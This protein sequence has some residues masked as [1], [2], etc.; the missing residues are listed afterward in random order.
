MI[1]FLIEKTKLYDQVRGRVD[2][3]QRRALDRIFREGPDG[4][5][6]GLSAANYLS[7]T[8]ATRAT[9]TRDLSDRIQSDD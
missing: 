1:D 6:G 8:G 3:R 2:E 5:K 9:A 4:F 7:I